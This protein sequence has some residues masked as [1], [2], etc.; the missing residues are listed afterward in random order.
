RV[1]QVVGLHQVLV[2]DGLAGLGIETVQIAHGAEGIDPAGAHQGRDSR[3]AGIGNP[4]TTVVLVFPDGLA[5]GGV[6]AEDPLL[7]GDAVAG[8]AKRLA[9]AVRG[10]QPI[11]DED[12]LAD[13]GRAAVALAQGDAPENPRTVLG[14]FLYQTRLA[15]DPVALRSQ[16]LGPIVG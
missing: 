12:A 1:A 7:A 3:P 5:R 10:P 15:P 8:G 13:H 11:H 9:R 6:Q 4:V 2:P 14:E 16:P